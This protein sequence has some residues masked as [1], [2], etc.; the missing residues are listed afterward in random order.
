[1]DVNGTAAARRRIGSRPAIQCCEALRGM[2]RK[3]VRRQP[4][5]ADGDDA[6]TLPVSIAVAPRAVRLLRPSAHRLDEPLHD[7]GRGMAVGG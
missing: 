5:Q 1:V 2:G 4:V 6:L 7:L 3:A